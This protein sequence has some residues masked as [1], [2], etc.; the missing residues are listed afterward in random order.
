MSIRAPLQEIGFLVSSADYSDGSG[1]NRFVVH[2]TTADKTFTRAGAGA[3][4]FGVL[5]NDPAAGEAGNITVAGVEKVLAGAAVV[6]GAQ[7]M[8]DANGKAITAT[9]TNQRLGIALES[10]SAAD[11]YIA[12][13]LQPGGGTA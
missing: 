3:F 5:T 8:S 6:R 11:E 1:R 12:V 2:S 4:G 9:A 10:A 7:V 13:L